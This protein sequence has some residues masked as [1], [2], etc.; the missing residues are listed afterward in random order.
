G[1]YHDNTGQ[2]AV[3]ISPPAGSGPLMV[4]STSDAG[5]GSLRAAIQAANAAA[6]A[7]GIAFRI[8]GA[9]PFTIASATLLPALS[10]TVVIDATTQPGY[11]GAPIVAIA[12]TALPP[13]SNGLVLT[14]PGSTVRGLAIHSFTTATLAGG[15]AIVLSGANGTIAGNYLG[16]D[17]SGV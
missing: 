14:A 2:F 8:P 7:Q 4:T 13:D 15:N 3:T 9:G 1:D 17:P 11:A 6:G 12:G 16:L 5:A 10:D